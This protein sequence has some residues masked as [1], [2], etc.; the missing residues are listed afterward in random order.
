[1]VQ[2]TQVDKAN[3]DGKALSGQGA[4]FSLPPCR[5]IQGQVFPSGGSVVSAPGSRHVRAGGRQLRGPHVGNSGV[6]SA[7]HHLNPSWKPRAKAGKLAAWQIG[8]GQAGFQ[9]P[10]VTAWAGSLKHTWRKSLDGSQGSFGEGV[11]A[12]RADFCGQVW[13]GVSRGLAAGIKVK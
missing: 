2:T 1:M 4:L 9:G 7:C 12:R 5:W 8:Q 6:I 13:K 3:W 11:Q 10:E